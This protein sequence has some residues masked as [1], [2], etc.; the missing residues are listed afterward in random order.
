MIT[1]RETTYDDVQILSAIQ[2]QAFLPIYEIYHDAG[3]PCLRGPEDISRRLDSPVFR[4]FTIFFEG[5]IAGGIMYRCA[6]ATPFIAQ[7][8][9]DEYY[10]TRVYIRP[11]LQSKHIA[12]EAILMSEKEFP[13]AKVFHVDFPEELEKNRKCY[14]ACGFTDTGKRLEAEPGLV[15][16]CYRKLV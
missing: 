2:R 1:I 6:G 10:L 5:E 8:P 16:A 3:N 14:E 15:L 12:R 4:C 11:E 13:G 9:P 7:L